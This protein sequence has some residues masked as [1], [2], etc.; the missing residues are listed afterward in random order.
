MATTQVIFQFLSPGAREVRI[1]PGYSNQVLAYVWAG[2]GGS[3]QF[4]TGGGGGGFVAGI[5]TI[6][7]ADDVLISVGSPGGSSQIFSGG[8]NGR[9]FNSIIPLN[10]GSGG[11]GAGR[12]PGGGG[13]GASSITVNGN[14]AIV[15]GG[16]GGGAGVNSNGFPGGSLGLLNT[17]SQGA[18][19][20]SGGGGGGGGYPYGGFQ[21]S[22]GGGG[23][24]QNYYDEAL[25]SSQIVQSGSG[26]TPGGTTSSFYPKR[27]IGSSGFSGAIILVFI[28][29]FTAWI[30]N[31]GDWK[32]AN[33][34]WIKVPEST[35]RYTR[36][37]YSSTGVISAV[38]DTAVKSPAG[39]K[40]IVRAFTKVNG[41]WES[42][43]TPAE[44][45]PTRASEFPQSYVTVNLIIAADVNNYNLIDFLAATNYYPGRTIINLTIDPGVVVGSDTAGTP[46]LSIDGL[47]KGDVVTLVNYGRIQGKGG[48]GGAAGSYVVTTTSTGGG[49]V[50]FCFPAGTMI[51][52]PTGLVAIETIQSGDLVYA[53]DIGTDLN[54]SAEL[55]A[56]P[57]TQIHKHDWV[58]GVSPLVVIKHTLGE[59]IVTAE[60]EILCL[61]KHDP[62]SDYPGFVRAE[63]LTEGDIIYSEDGT[64]SV[65]TSIELGP[66]YDTVYNFEVADFHTYVANGIRVHNGF[67]QPSTNKYNVRVT[68]TRIQSVPGLPGEPGGTALYV[69]YPITLENN[70]TIAG[71]GGG[72]GGGGGP[73][74]GQ[75]GGGAAFGLGAN[76]GTL[77]AGGAGV[78]FGGA[79]GAP[80]ADGGNGTNNSSNGGRGGA[81][82]F[83]IYGRENVSLTI[84]GTIVG[85]SKFN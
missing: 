81:A 83:V 44:L 11:A 62:D 59:L 66:V 68:T 67:T 50:S 23:G 80:G 18:N 1:P 76:N 19:G 31:D 16:G 77:T 17:N 5:V 20:D 49:I 24:G 55:V 39:W 82:G 29:N 79:G 74:G 53:Y 52:T 6:N 8:Q 47:T 41:R 38:N 58:N 84:T 10:G 72:G 4:N 21:L 56:K 64:A 61:N 51:S 37:V 3:G 34:A 40:S 33:N 63:N 2:G 45:N 75:G 60:H 26:T 7:A 9:G 13:G 43:Q 73:T 12:P 70:G 48:A 65:V 69:T 46:A 78:G 35:V 27:K 57:V 14:V 30:K 25:V 32:Q 15:S 36:T 22:G 42:V 28:K 85:P 71:G 54:S